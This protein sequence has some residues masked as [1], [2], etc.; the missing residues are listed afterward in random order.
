[1]QHVESLADI[2]SWDL[3]H[4]EVTISQAF[5]NYF[6]VRVN[7]VRK[8]SRPWTILRYECD[9][10][11]STSKLCM[12][13][14]AF[15][16][17]HIG[18]AFQLREQ[19]LIVFH[20]TNEMLLLYESCRPEFLVAAQVRHLCLIPLEFVKQEVTII[21]PFDQCLFVLIP[22]I[23][24]SLLLRI[25]LFISSSYNLFLFP[26]SFFSFSSK[27]RNNSSVYLNLSSDTLFFLS[28]IKPTSILGSYSSATPHYV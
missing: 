3:C 24:N 4:T 1:M 11:N 14:S 6:G 28:R 5:T 17:A 15:E 19:R 27:L 23:L 22:C 10:P 2:V 16:Y 18:S 9:I 21:V 8:R 26:N 13:K 12:Y 7:Y 25:T 20:I